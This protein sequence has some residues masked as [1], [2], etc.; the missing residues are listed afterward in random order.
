[1]TATV[2][3]FPSSRAFANAVRIER[4]LGGEGWLTITPRG[5][6]WVEGNFESALCFAQDVANGFGFGIISSAG[7][8][9]PC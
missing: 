2:I 1:M 7:R 6:G 3:R 8:I 4:E 5:H 9:A